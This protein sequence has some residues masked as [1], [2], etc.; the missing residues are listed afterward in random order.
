VETDAARRRGAPWRWPL[1]RKFWAISAI[2]RPRIE[3]LWAAIALVVAVYAA[4]ELF[5]LGGRGS[6]GLFNDWINDLLL[7]TAAL[8]CLAGAIRQVRGRPAWLIVSLALVSWA[9]GDTIWSIR[10]GGGAHVPET[11][12]SAAFWLAWYPLIIVALVLLVRDRVAGFDLRRWIDGIAVMVMVA[13]PWVALFLEPALNRAHASTLARALSF[14][15]PLGDAVLFGAILGVFVVMA[16]RPGRMWLALGVAI[17]VKK[18]E[19]AIAQR[20]N[21]TT[22]GHVV[23]NPQ[24]VA[25]LESKGLKNAQS[26]EEVDAPLKWIASCFGTLGVSNRWVTSPPEG[27][28]T[29][30]KSGAVIVSV[31]IDTITSD[32]RMSSQVMLDAAVSSASPIPMSAAIG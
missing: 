26:V 12:I 8:A 21:V 22:L 29:V 24:M 9:I 13:T 32:R 30:K 7:W 31:P 25:A 10:F 17:T 16:W 11:S 14:V 23:H 19:D 20:Q 3:F 5:G 27:S 18:A 6:A 2:P 4:H 1:I 28:A 15:Y